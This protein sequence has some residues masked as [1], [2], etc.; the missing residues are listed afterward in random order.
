MN[1]YDTNILF[2]TSY[3]ILLIYVCQ[4]NQFSK[5][6]DV[7]CIVI[8]IIIYLYRVKMCIVNVFNGCFFKIHCIYIYI[9]YNLTCFIII[10]DK[11]F[12]IFRL[13]SN[14]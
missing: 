1:G 3:V 6:V 2:C 14:K 8:F 10:I 13:R 5:N 4:D 12:I 9:W 11:Y 7:F